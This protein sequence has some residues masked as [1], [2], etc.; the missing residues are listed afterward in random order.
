MITKVAEQVLAV[1][2]CWLRLR[3]IVGARVDVFSLNI[4]RQL[5][6]IGKC[7]TFTEIKPE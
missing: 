5:N 4:A 2:V 1:R 3:E 6:E 7:F